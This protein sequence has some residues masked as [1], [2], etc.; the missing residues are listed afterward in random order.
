MEI[1]PLKQQF[2]HSCLV[3]CLLMISRMTDQSIEER[4]FSEGEKRRFGFY[5]NSILESFADN[6]MLSV[7][8]YVDNKFFADKLVGEQNRKNKRIK[9]KNEKISIELIKK[10]TD[11]DAVIAHVDNNF[12][13]DYSHS[14]HF[15]VVEKAIP[16]G[17]FQ[18]I[19]PLSGKSKIVAESIL[20]SAIVSLKNHI[21]MCPIV[22]QKTQNLK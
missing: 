7:D 14:P 20:E 18:I 4:I 17:K 16:T 6:T 1:S 15:I 11:I 2:H 5:L 10:L 12:F 9:F 8:V 21:K 13:G 3:T 22:I 19:D